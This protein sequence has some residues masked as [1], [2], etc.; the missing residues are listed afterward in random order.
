MSVVDPQPPWLARVMRGFGFVG[1]AVVAFAHCD[2]AVVRRV[3]ANALARNHLSDGRP[4]GVLVGPRK[5]S[6]FRQF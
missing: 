1:F 4:V 5:L 6:E 2:K 3:M